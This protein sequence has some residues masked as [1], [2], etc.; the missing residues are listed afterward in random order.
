VGDTHSEK[1]GKKF[2][3]EQRVI[4]GPKFRG[5][6]QEALV[7][8][9]QLLGDFWTGHNFVEGLGVG[10]LGFKIA[11][12]LGRGEV[13][14]DKGDDL[15]FDKVEVNGCGNAQMALFCQVQ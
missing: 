11:F 15:A 7:V 2:W 1:F 10:S 8:N 9:P 5:A 12:D 4:R 3:S 13:P 6:R 14:E